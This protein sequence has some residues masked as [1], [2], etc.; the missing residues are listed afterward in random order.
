M[1]KTFS[2]L[3]YVTQLLNARRPPI[4]S[5]DSYIQDEREECCI[6]LLPCKP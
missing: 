2:V 5:K 6:L 4:N 1:Y 3:L